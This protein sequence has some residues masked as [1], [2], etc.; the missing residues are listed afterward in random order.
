MEQKSTE[1]V[2]VIN[3][4]NGV[5]GIDL[6]DLKIRRRWPKKGAKVDLNKADLQEAMYDPGVEYLFKAGILYIEDLNTKKELELEPEDAVA[7][8]NIIVLTDKEKEDMLNSKK[9]NWEFKQILGKLSLDQV[10][11]LANFAIKQEVIDVP[12]NEAIKELSGIDILRA[13]QLEHMNKE[14]V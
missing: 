13:I 11:D 14:E 2:T 10:I 8:V 7:P 9:P 5:V 12:K 3:M 1:K 6:P 4:S